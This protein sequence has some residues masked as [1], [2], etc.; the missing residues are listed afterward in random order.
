MSRV[1]LLQQNHTNA[2]ENPNPTANYTKVDDGYYIW[3]PMNNA[4]IFLVD[5]KYGNLRHRWTAKYI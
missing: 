3:S 4:S 2:K 5:K 1:F